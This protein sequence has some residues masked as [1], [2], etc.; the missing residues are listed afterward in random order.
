MIHELVE[1]KNVLSARLNSLNDQH[2]A[3]VIV[4]EQLQKE[5]EQRSKETNSKP[6]NTQQPGRKST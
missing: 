2:A 3:L 1:E 4:N 5:T 6:T